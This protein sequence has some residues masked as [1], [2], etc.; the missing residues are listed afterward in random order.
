M[1][2]KPRGDSKLDALSPAQ[3]ERLAEWLTI[4]NLTYAEAL[5]RVR[6]EFGV[7]TSRSALHGFFTR[8]AAPWKYA[9]ARGEAET[10]AGLMEGQFDAATIKKAKQLAFDAVAGPRPDLKSARTLLKIIGDT[11]KQQLA[12]RRLEL[13]TRK[14][15]LLEAKAALADRAKGISDNSAL[16]PEEKAA[17]LRALFG[18]G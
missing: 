8:V 4:E 12:E 10:F 3:Q 13:D 9:Q 5:V 16:T 7:S 15:T 17:Q 11:A 1:N 2:R 18:M 14:V 6:E